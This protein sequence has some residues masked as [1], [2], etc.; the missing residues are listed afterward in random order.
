M[1][2]QKCVQK[3]SDCYDQSVFQQE[4]ENDIKHPKSENKPHLT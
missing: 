3:E 4:T 2:T 1:V